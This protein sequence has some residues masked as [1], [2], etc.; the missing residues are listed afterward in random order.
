MNSKIGT[1]VILAST[2]YFG[3]ML[4]ALYILTI[5]P[6]HDILKDETVFT[7]SYQKINGNWK[8]LKYTPE[9]SI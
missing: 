6:V 5:G 3:L 8:L 9:I 4:I 1:K 2:L 7:E